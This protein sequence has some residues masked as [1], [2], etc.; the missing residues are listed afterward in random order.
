M[1]VKLIFDDPRQQGSLMSMLHETLHGRCA[2][3]WGDIYL[4]PRVAFSFSHIPDGLPWVVCAF[5]DDTAYVRFDLF[6][7]GNARNVLRLRRQT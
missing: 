4:S 5:L 2:L 6:S 3:E 7:L 1:P